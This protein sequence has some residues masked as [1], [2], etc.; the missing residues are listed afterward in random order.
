MAIAHGGAGGQGQAARRPPP[1]SYPDTIHRTEISRR[2]DRGTFELLSTHCSP[3]SNRASF[4]LSLACFV[5]N[6]RLP[7]PVSHRTATISRSG[8]VTSRRRRVP[9]PRCRE[10]RNDTRIDTRRQHGTRDPTTQG[11]RARLSK[12]R[13]KRSCQPSTSNRVSAVSSLA[14]WCRVVDLLPPAVASTATA[15]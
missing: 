8:N 10:H 9:P 14:L 2:T 12:G 15:T 1:I 3:R 13:D 4:G 7:T 5:S 11:L 6:R